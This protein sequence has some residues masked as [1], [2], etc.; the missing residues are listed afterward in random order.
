MAGQAFAESAEGALMRAATYSPSIKK[1][2]K[3]ISS[4][5]DYPTGA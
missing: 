1:T 3:W 5:S 4:I 2:P